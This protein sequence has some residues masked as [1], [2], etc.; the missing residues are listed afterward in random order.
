MGIWGGTDEDQQF[1][2]GDID[3]DYPKHG[4]L[5]EHGC[6]YLVM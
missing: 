2:Q 4:N 1:E 3:R 5:G 6:K